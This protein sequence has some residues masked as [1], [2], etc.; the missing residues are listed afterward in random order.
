[1]YT[2]LIYELTSVKYFGIIE[3]NDFFIIVLRFFILFYLFIDIFIHVYYVFPSDDSLFLTLQLLL[4]S[5]HF[6]LSQLHLLSF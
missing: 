3:I 6:S 2:N 4:I 1:M 5:H